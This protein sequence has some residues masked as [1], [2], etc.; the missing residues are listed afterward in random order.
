MSLET[1]FLFSTTVFIASIIPGPS[2]LL[3]LNHGI[4]HGKRKSIA[5]ALGVTTAAALMGFVSL[6]GLSAVIVAS[7]I[8]FQVIKYLG[9][10]YLIYLGIKVWCSPVTESENNYEEKYKKIRTSYLKLYFQALLVGLS[11]PKAII[12]FTALFPQFLNPSL[13]QVNQ[14][15]ILLTTLSFVAFLCMMIYVISGQ[16]LAPILKKIKY[17]KILNKINGGL[18]VCFGSAAAISD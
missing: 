5:T 18:F 13:P 1:W 11:N 10:G 3:G 9:A 8:V 17:R 6:L 12:F 4:I 15:I 7:G 2:V 16:T 14:F